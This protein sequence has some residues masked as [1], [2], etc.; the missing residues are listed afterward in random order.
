M[1]FLPAAA[2]DDDGNLTDT[3]HAGAKVDNAANAA[4]TN[5]DNN[6]GNNTKNLIGNT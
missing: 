2:V 3:H 4:K 6:S 1:S 5:S